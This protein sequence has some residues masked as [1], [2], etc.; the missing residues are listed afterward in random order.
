MINYFNRLFSFIIPV[1]IIF[2]SKRLYSTD[3]Q[4]IITIIV[5]FSNFSYSVGFF[6]NQVEQL[7][8]EK[9]DLFFPLAFPLI[10]LFAFDF[11]YY[12]KAFV[13]IHFLS[14]FMVKNLADFF[15]NPYRFHSKN[16]FNNITGII[17]YLWPHN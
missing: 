15:V 5:F 13:L 16:V 2:F 8:T 17:F 11:F 3:E 6:G 14:I 4:F 10:L 9:E 12:S 1:L 7:K